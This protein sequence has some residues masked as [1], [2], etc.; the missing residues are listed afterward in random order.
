M[1]CQTYISNLVYISLQVYQRSYSQVGHGVL[2]DMKRVSLLKLSDKMSNKFVRQY[3]RQNP[4]WS[5]WE[6]E[7][8]SPH[9]DSKIVNRKRPVLLTLYFVLL[10]FYF[11]LLTLYFVLLTLLCSANSLLCSANSL[12]CSADFLGVNTD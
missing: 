5:E 8:E 11:V 1:Q 12:L 9:S 6:W 7:W 2:S 10:T 4:P 3:V